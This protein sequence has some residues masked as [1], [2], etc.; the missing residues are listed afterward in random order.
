LNFS[1]NTS[2][3][4]SG[5]RGSSLP[6]VGKKIP[7]VGEKIPRLKYGDLTIRGLQGLVIDSVAKNPTGTFC[8]II[9]IGIELAK[10]SGSTK[11][12]YQK[13]RTGYE[14]SDYKECQGQPP[15]MGGTSH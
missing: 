14:A 8:E 7:K 15:G 12:G 11:P 1:G 2:G 4:Y 9:N 3:I 5:N 10:C 6:I 13:T